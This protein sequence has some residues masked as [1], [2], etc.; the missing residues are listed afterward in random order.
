MQ[1][2]SMLAF[3]EQHDSGRGK[4]RTSVSAVEPVGMQGMQ[5]VLASPPHQKPM[6]QSVVDLNGHES[7]SAAQVDAHCWFSLQWSPQHSAAE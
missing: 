5:R 2:P 6:Q 1:S 3:R 4:P 7:F